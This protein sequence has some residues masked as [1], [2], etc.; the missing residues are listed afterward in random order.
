MGDP[1]GDGAVSHAE[2]LL[3]SNPLDAS[4][5]G[6]VQPKI[7]PGEF[8]LEFLQPVNRALVVETPGLGG[9]WHAVQ[10]PGNQFGFPAVET[11]RKV[12][13]PAYE[14]MRLFR[15]RVVEP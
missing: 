6:A 14:G 4:S 3:G 13:V 15:V 12:S 5:K 9:V 11:P 2:Y 10:A 8:T 7:R 1:D